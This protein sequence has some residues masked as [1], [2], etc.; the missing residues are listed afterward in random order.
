MNDS[1]IMLIIFALLL[2]VAYFSIKD[3]K[4]DRYNIL[5]NAVYI[6]VGILAIRLALYIDVL[7]FIIMA[8]YSVTLTLIKVKKQW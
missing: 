8:L 1:L 7:P 5:N 4:S 6:I 3:I 2:V